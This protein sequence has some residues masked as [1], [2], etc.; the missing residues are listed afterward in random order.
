MFQ[1]VITP[2][3]HYD[4][5][6]QHYDSDV[7][8]W[9]Y[10]APDRIMGQLQSVLRYHPHRPAVLDVGIGTGLLSG[11]CR[12]VRKDCHITGID[13]SSRMLDFCAQKQVAD[14]LY[15]VDVEQDR[16]P[17][18][19]GRFD[20][21]MAAGL[22]EHVGSISSALR[23][24]ARVTKPGGLIAF[25]YIPSLSQLTR[26]QLSKKLRPGRTPE[27]RFVLGDLNIYRHNPER[28]KTILGMAGAQQRYAER[29]VG[30][31]TYVVVTVPY[32]LFVAQKL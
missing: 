15:Q 3:M 4:D 20:I 30:Y 32:D 13:V 11:K 18:E 14:D 23:E 27:G 22:M 31:R 10:H 6:A 9:G 21:V 8:G 2:E 16:F 26:E 29:F 17:F 19:E 24:M 28:V 12:S 1:S 25:T 5:W 7:K